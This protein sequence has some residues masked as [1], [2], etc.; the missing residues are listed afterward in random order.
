MVAAY[1]LYGKSINCIVEVSLI[2]FPSL[3]L[4]EVRQLEPRSNLELVEPQLPSAVAPIWVR[5][6]RFGAANREVG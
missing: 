1:E 6:R 3:V 2:Q 5:S 4:V